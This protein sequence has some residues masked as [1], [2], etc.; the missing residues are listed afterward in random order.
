VFLDGPVVLCQAVGQG[1]EVHEGLEVEDLTQV[2]QELL[3]LAV[4][5][6]E[7][8]FDLLALGQVVF[9]EQHLLLVE[10]LH[11]DVG[12]EFLVDASAKVELDLVEV[13]MLELLGFLQD[14]A[15]ALQVHQVEDLDLVQDALEFGQQVRHHR[16][17]LQ[18]SHYLQVQPVQRHQQTLHLVHVVFDV[19]Q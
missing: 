3:E 9:G 1:V 10:Q 4:R 6:H 5:D 7:R 15:A 17:L 13:H 11:V 14:L 12:V 16:V 8:A 19:V 2:D 18:A